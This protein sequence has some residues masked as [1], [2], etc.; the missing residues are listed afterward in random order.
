MSMQL[1]RDAS[2]AGGTPNPD[3]IYVNGI[4]PDTGTYA[5]PPVSIEELAKTVRV[6]PGGAEFLDLHTDAARSF[7]PPFG[8][9]LEKIEEVGWG[10]V[11][12]EDT[13]KV[14][15]DAL[16]PLVEHRRKKAGD[17]V[18][19]LECKK[20][21]QVRDW[22]SRMHV[23]AGNLD[24]EVVPYYLLLVG[25]PTRIPFEFQYL[26]GVE[27]AVGRLAFDTAAEYEHYTGSVIAYETASAL[28]N[29]RE[30]V[31]WGTCHPADPATNLST[32]LLI[33]PLANGVEGAPGLLKRPIHAEVG[34]E[35]KLFCRDEATRQNLLAVLGSRKPPSVLFTASH[36]L[37]IRPGKPNQATDQ[38]GLICQ[39]W[40]GYGSIGADHYLAAVNVG[41]DAN[42]SGLV[43]FLF[44]CFGAGTPDADQFLMDLSQTAVAKPL[45]AQPFVAA[46]PQRLLTHPRGSALAVIGH[47]DRAWGFSI[48]PPKTTGAQIG[49]FR[50]GLGFIL[51]GSPVGHAVA[52]QFGQRYAAL[53]TTLLSAV[54]PTA[55]AYMRLNDR[56]L[57][58]H[59]LQRND[60]QNYVMLGDPA[61]SIR[62]DALS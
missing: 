36:G 21:E 34:Y 25:P 12:H 32:S 44:A 28:R 40:P 54:S 13:P 26:L 33:E 62:K 56:D 47:I 23:S 9:D 22:Y 45:A 31:Y 1:D 18:K 5:V 60:A 8:M 6:R 55:P 43:A 51:N 30:I 57:V 19:V 20:G 61:V 39:D 17:L 10:I 37:A 3:L 7:A 48:Q 59:W 2:N 29:A 42:V 49:P 41:D 46:L 24:P 16:M 15:R 38:G 58:T 53:S 27:Y 11:Y 52:L 50:N 35:R 4:D 14:L